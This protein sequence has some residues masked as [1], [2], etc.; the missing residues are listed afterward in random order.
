MKKQSTMTDEQVLPASPSPAMTENTESTEASPS[1]AH[2][3]VGYRVIRTMSE[4]S[5]SVVYKAEETRT[6]R[7]VTI[8]VFYSNS[9]ATAESLKR[10]ERDAEVLKHLNHPDL[11]ALYDVGITKDGGYYVISEYVRGVSLNEYVRSQKPSPKERMDIFLKICDAVQYAHQYCL[12]HRDLTPSNIIIG[13]KGIVKVQGFGV[14]LLSNRNRG[15]TPETK[16]KGENRPELPSRS[17]E[18]SRNKP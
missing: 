15:P 16:S 13:G 5:A 11:A 9:Y 1:V 3:F 12:L 10:F 2:S 8:G 4:D 14:A 18:Q 6:K 17:P 7:T